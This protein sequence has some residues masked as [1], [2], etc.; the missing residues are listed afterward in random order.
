MKLNKLRMSDDGG[1]SP[2]SAA[3]GGVL[4][5]RLTVL[6]SSAIEVQFRPPLAPNGILTSYILTRSTQAPPLS[7]PITFGATMLP[8]SDGYFIYEDTNLLPF[9]NY[10]YLITACTSAGCTSS[11]SVSE[12][13][14]EDTP[15]GIATPVPLVLNSS[16]ILVS[17]EEPEQP[18]GVIQS[19]DLFRTDLG[20]YNLSSGLTNCCQDYLQNGNL[21]DGC[22]FVTQTGSDVTSYT[23]GNLQAYSFFEYCIVVT[24]GADSVYSK[25]SAPVRTLPAPMPRVGPVLTATTISST[26]IQLSWSSLEISDLLGPLEGYTLYGNIAGT[27]GLGEVLF[28]GLA[29]SYLATGLIASTEYVFV[30]SCLCDPKFPFPRCKPLQSID[31]S[32]L[33]P[34][35]RWP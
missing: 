14:F 24:N 5:P 32:I 10:T 35:P 18:N 11:D 27:P 20:F 9:T 6:S 19:Y 16:S 28:T 7:I 30:V 3:P 1:N 26:A 22:S 4:P 34:P 12:V 21:T 23:D 17:W 2:P 31:P 13:T 25:V 15:T 33:T 8:M 29:Q